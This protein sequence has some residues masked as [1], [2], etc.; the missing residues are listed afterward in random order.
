[1]TQQSLKFLIDANS[2][3]AIAQI[4]R[5]VEAVYGLGNATLS[6][7][8]DAADAY[9]QTQQSTDALARA[10]EAA[11][12]RVRQAY[13]Q[14]RLA[15]DPLYASSQRYE[16][17][18]GTVSAAL[19][20]QVIDQTE[21]NRVLAL[22]EQRYVQAGRAATVAA[23]QSTQLG[24]SSGAMASKVQ[25][26]AFQ[27]GDFAV[28]VA[29]GTSALRA[30]AQQLPQFLGGFGVW[31]AVIG[32]AVAVLAAL[33]PALFNTGKEA[34]KA[35]T[36]IKAYGDSFGLIKTNIQDAAALE[37]E[38]TEALKSGS[39][40]RI[41]AIQAEAAV[42]AKLLELDLIDQKEAQLAASQTVDSVQAALS[43]AQDVV[44]ARQQQIA[45][46]LAKGA[47]GTYSGGF[48]TAEE[49]AKGL[50]EALA[51][52]TKELER[53]QRLRDRSSAQYKL[54][55]AQIAANNDRLKITQDLLAK[56]ASGADETKT[57][58]DKS[59]GAALSLADRVADAVAAAINLRDAA[60]GDGW[61]SSAIGQATT[62]ANKLWDAAGAALA[63]RAANEA[64]VRLPGGVDALAR[65]EI[66]YSQRNVTRRVP[67]VSTGSGSSD[68]GGGSS[69][70]PVADLQKSGTD[71]LQAMEDAIGAVNEKV[72]LGLMSTAEGA[73]AIADAKDKA[74][75]ALAELIPQL[76][77]VAGPAAKGFVDSWR[78]AIKDMQT[79]MTE[80]GQQISESLSS[81]FESAFAS[82]IRNAGQGKNA[83]NSFTNAV[84][85]DM[86]KMASNKFTSSFVTPLFNSLL[87]GLG[88]GGGFSLFAQ[89]GVPSVQAFAKG[90]MPALP[91]F[92]N[93]IVDRP[94]FFAM[95]GTRTGVMGEAGAEA[96]MPLSR[97]RDGKLGVAAQGG[98]AQVIINNYTS[99]NVTAQTR[100]DGGRTFTE[101]AIREVKGAIVD[102]IARGG[103]VSD[104]MS[105]SFGLSRKGY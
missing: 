38:Y 23:S 73:K 27:I 79:G 52:E 102:D 64:V 8:K 54:I 82:L 1:M 92:R 30:G 51:E 65:G 7:N 24:N 66:N 43:R 90:G 11:A 19:E 36:A 93:A 18:V 69:S 44:A 34:D 26:A 29:G 67:I 53:Q 40:Q 45:D 56:I 71:A 100:S 12:D 75:N 48:A 84:L 39:Q 80:A 32:G 6:V 72:S 37:G 21:A 96:I 50:Q 83:F 41:D 35:K 31:G 76:Q 70:N 88:G 86:A 98:G 25:N 101:I 20:A 97:G 5:A 61:L 85:D 63:A 74:G 46:L 9:R 60:P 104:A 91:A 33:I 13:E 68:S 58:F 94:T 105:A 42:R 16:Q 59:A 77:R 49:E 78:S 22:A 62:L 103:D 4:K 95:G 15:L 99:A 3:Q 10:T 55:E 47:A 81:N 17:V 28:Q 89:G 87:G 57:N 2:D 14:Q